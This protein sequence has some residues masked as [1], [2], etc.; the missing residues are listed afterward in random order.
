MPKNKNNVQATSGNVDNGS[1]SGT[2]AGNT[3]TKGK[4]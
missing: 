2:Q 4:K 3:N 1:K